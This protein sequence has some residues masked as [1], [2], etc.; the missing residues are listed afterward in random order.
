MEKLKYFAK[1]FWVEKHLAQWF[2]TIMI[3]VNVGLGVAVLAG[4][5][6]RFTVPSY[7]PL[8]DFV[9]GETWIWG[10]WVVLAAMLMSV[11]FRW[12][13]IIGL[14]LSAFWH[15]I[16]MACFAIAVVHYPDAAATPIPVYG[17]FA[18]VSAALL[19]A[20]VIDKSGG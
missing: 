14:W 18:M 16:W 11:P 1:G 8:I 20:R 9:N 15:I 17:G 5:K 6:E 12:P 19:T 4:G 3:M 10:A 13:N 7:S 2:T